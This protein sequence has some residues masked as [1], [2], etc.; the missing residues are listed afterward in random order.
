MFKHTLENLYSPANLLNG[1]RIII[2]DQSVRDRIGRENVKKAIDENEI[3][4][5]LLPNESYSKRVNDIARIVS[6]SGKTCYV[7]ANKPHQ[8]LMK[9]FE[10]SGIDSKNFFFIDCVTKGS[11]TDEK[12]IYVSSP[13]ALTE[14]NIA[15]KKVLEME[16]IKLTLFDSL[17]TLL[18]SV[19]R[20]LGSKGVLI[21][22]K[23]DAK[24]E[25][26]K[27]LN[28]FVDKVVEMG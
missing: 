9:E 6:E 11:P 23:D 18:I 26:I 21:T 19:F 3:T 22:L 28:M 27:D 8:T 16:K 4:L 10:K 17:S 12:V 2:K 25:L 20:T 24:S 5:L 7:A 14:M 15:I 13:K 1:V